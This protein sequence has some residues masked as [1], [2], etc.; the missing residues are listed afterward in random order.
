MKS[1]STFSANSKYIDKERKIR[2]NDIYLILLVYVF[3][4]SVFVVR[5]KKTMFKRYIEK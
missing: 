2:N 1:E 5:Y 3:D 4:S